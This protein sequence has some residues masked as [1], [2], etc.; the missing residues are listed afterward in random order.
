MKGGRL[1]W[2]SLSCIIFQMQSPFNVTA[3]LSSAAIMARK[4][5]TYPPDTQV[6]DLAELRQIIFEL[7][8]EDEQ[9]AG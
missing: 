2:A 4:A 9:E 3:L 8:H 1:R 6:I 7:Q 5:G